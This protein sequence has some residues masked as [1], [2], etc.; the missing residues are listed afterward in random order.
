MLQQS[1]NRTKVCAIYET[2][3]IPATNPTGGDIVDCYLYLSDPGHYKP[4]FLAAKTYGRYPEGLVCA[5]QHDK[6]AVKAIF[7]KYMYCVVSPY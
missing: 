7:E 2:E 4:E 1:E 3:D 5:S 6:K